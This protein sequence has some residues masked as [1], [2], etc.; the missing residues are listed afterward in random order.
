MLR[1]PVVMAP[2]QLAAQLIRSPLQRLY[3]AKHFIYAVEECVFGDQRCEPSAPPT[4][5]RR[6]LAPPPNLS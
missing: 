4:P 1:V 2:L 3:A 6:A 5:S